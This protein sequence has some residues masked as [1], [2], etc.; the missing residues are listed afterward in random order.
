LSGSDFAPP[1]PESKRPGR[2]AFTVTDDLRAS[3][4]TQREAGAELPVI[5]ASLGVSVPTLRKYFRA[6]LARPAPEAPASLF[7]A[8]P[9]K[10]PPNSPRPRKPP[11]PKPDTGRPARLPL[12][13]ERQRVAL[14]IAVNATQAE[15]ARV[16]KCSEPWLR[17]HFR[18]ELDAGAAM[19][20]TELLEATWRAA[21]KG[22][23]GAIKILQ[24]RFDRADIE[25]FD[26]DNNGAGQR[27]GQPAPKSSAPP[28]PEPLGKKAQADADADALIEADPKIAALFGPRES[29]RAA[30]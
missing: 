18:E 16:L 22:N 11:K 19:K 26:R 21:K 5:A 2:A 25:R 12:H 14:M 4:R 30:H 1:S 29:R 10:R 3:V 17:E 13:E 28:K 9:A 7:D 15:I 8:A 27:P 23:A 24:D 6:E 20:R